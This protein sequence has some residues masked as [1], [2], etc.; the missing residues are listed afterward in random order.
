MSW[1]RE[2]ARW[3]S[4]TGVSYNPAYTIVF[5]KNFVPEDHLNWALSHHH[6]TL[7]ITYF[8]SQIKSR[9]SPPTPIKYSAL[10]GQKR[11]KVVALLRYEY[12][13][14]LNVLGFLDLGRLE[15]LTPIVIHFSNAGWEPRQRGQEK[16]LQGYLA[17][18]SGCSE[19]VVIQ[20]DSLISLH[21]RKENTTIIENYRVLCPFTNYYD[22]W[23]VC[24]NETKFVWKKNQKVFAF[25]W[26]WCGR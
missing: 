24:V 19:E 16:H 21:W 26:E 23:Y 12:K 13:S 17:D 11:H 15:S 10:P 8:T 22:K 20:R 9:T 7:L 4:Y 5:I 14:C 2:L 6:F 18:L 1:S 3:Y 25:W